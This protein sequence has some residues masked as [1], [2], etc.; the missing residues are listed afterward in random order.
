MSL[1]DFLND[2]EGIRE[3]REMQDRLALAETLEEVDWPQEGRHDV[4]KDELAELFCFLKE[5]HRRHGLC[6]SCTLDVYLLARDVLRGQ[7]RV[8][9]RRD[10][11]TAQNHS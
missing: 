3:L 10:W 7:A 9:L 2:P 5:W 8:C 4:T 1:E 6:P 11:P